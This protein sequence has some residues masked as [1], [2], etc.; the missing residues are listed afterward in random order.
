[1][2]AAQRPPRPNPVVVKVGRR[3]YSVYF[4]Y[5]TG[6][7]RTVEVHKGPWKTQRLDI[8]GPTARAAIAKAG[9]A[10]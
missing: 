10:A 5:A 9:G 2:S 3:W 6:A 4:N 8:N 1:M 7:P